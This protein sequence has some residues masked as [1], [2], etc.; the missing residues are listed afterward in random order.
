MFA[1]E[2]G[3]ISESSSGL[4]NAAGSGFPTNPLQVSEK[5]ILADLWQSR[6]VCFFT[7]MF[8]NSLLSIRRL[9]RYRQ[10]P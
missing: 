4:S 3:R 6:E 9:Y 8:V 2:G 5:M 7:I 1:D 10:S